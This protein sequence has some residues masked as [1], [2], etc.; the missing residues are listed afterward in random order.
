[1]ENL[2]RAIQIQ[3][4]INI[5]L[6]L[7]LFFDRPA[8]GEENNSTLRHV[9]QDGLFWG[10]SRAIE[11]L[12]DDSKNQSPR[13]FPTHGLDHQMRTWLHGDFVTRES[14]PYEQTTR[15]ASDGLAAIL[16]GGSL[17]ES[18]MS[19]EQNSFW[20]LTHS[21]SLTSFIVTGTKALVRRQRPKRYYASDAKTNKDS[22]RSFPSG[23][24]AHAAAAATV[25]TLLSPNEP[26]KATLATVSAGTISYLRIRSDRH[27]FSDVVVGSLIGVSVSHWVHRNLRQSTS[28]VSFTAV[29]GYLKVTY[30][31]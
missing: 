24:A 31:F 28:S 1:M 26:M 17:L 23:H 10:L 30:H 29:P 3:P 2:L 9:L 6:V 5:L 13:K 11:T 27:F 21:M 4:P 14:T 7:L 15:D 12:P 22:V 18:V 8:K 16:I 19:T 20:Q 25:I